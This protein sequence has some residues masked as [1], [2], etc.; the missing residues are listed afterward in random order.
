VQRCSYSRSSEI[1][2]SYNSK[3]IN[4][5]VKRIND[6]FPD[7]VSVEYVCAGGHS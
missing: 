4:L 6:K 1:E 2:S 5:I 7:S 3:E